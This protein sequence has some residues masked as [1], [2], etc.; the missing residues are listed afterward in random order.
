M[1]FWGLGFEHIFLIGSTLSTALHS[2]KVFLKSKERTILG[3]VSCLWLIF[4]VNELE[5]KLYIVTTAFPLGR[6]LQLI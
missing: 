2:N 4:P 1:L 3:A 5:I 6:I